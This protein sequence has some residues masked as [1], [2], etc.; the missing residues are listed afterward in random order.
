MNSIIESARHSFDA[1]RAELNLRLQLRDTALLAYIVAVGAVVSFVFGG[2]NTSSAKVNILLI[3]PYLSLSYAFV[4]SQHNS[5]IASIIEFLNLDLRTEFKKQN[6]YAPQFVSSESFIKHTPDSNWQRSFSHFT[7][8]FIPSIFSLIVTLPNLDSVLLK[9]IWT[10]S[11]ISAVIGLMQVLGAYYKRQKIN[12]MI[13]YDQR[14]FYKFSNFLIKNSYIILRHGKSK[15]NELGIISS[16]LNSDIYGLSEQGKVEVERNIINGISMGVFKIPTKIVLY[17][18]PFL[19]TVETIK[20]AKKLLESTIE[21]K[22]NDA[23]S[24]RDFGT[25]ESKS[26]KNYI[27]VW[28]E[29]VLNPNHTKF[30]VESIFNV[31]KRLTR[32]IAY[33]EEEYSNQE[34]ILCCHGDVA[35][36]LICLFEQKK[37]SLHNKIIKFDT[38]EIR[39]YQKNV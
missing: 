13:E 26:S 1:A 29:D 10:A 20:I 27:K 37:L 11:V 30:G 9:I 39:R 7:V 4:V 23:L 34:I 38:G 19:R 15:A 3:I 14:N 25:F 8:M 36:V 33:L 21:V 22:I 35:S 28:N 18:S 5:V 2:S 31:Q 24:E 32:F 17:S 12:S 6:G 16:K